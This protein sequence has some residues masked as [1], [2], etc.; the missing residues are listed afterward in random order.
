M[1]GGRGG[2][3]FV[4]FETAEKTN[5]FSYPGR[6]RTSDHHRITGLE[7]EVGRTVSGGRLRNEKVGTGRRTR[8]GGGGGDHLNGIRGE[9]REGGEEEVALSRFCPPS[10]LRSI[11]VAC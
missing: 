3:G 6:E 10:F 5:P 9:T 2:G 4:D 8:R 7:G 1:G 11:E